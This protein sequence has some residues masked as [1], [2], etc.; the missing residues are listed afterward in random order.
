VQMHEFFLH[1]AMAQLQ[2]VLFGMDEEVME[3]TNS[4]IREVFAGTHKDSKY[5]RDIVLS[6]LRKVSENPAFATATD[7]AV[8]SG[9]K[10][11]FGPLSK[12]VVDA[13]STLNL[14]PLDQ[15]GNMMII[16]FAGHDTTGH[17]M[18]WLCYELSKHPEHLARLQAEVDAMFSSLGGR[19]MAYEDC[20][21]LPF[22][23]R[24]IVETLRLWPVVVNGTFRELEGDETIRGP[25][26]K[27]VTLPAGTF[28]QIPNWM[29]HRDPVLWGPDV[30]VFNP[31]RAFEGSEIWDGVPFHSSNPE[32]ARF[33]PFT[34]APR[35]CLGK[36]FAQLEMRAILSHVLRDF[37]FELS[38]PYKEHG[39]DHLESSFGTTGPRD[40]TPEGVAENARRREEGGFPQ[41][42]MYLHVVPRHFA[43]GSKL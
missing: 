1:E 42:A 18:T 26:G 37:S 32:S 12:S 43:A 33:S 31:D 13:I 27:A 38:A 40:V 35:H 10:P 3:S 6:M 15:F 2:L 8:V 9:E 17:T 41:L 23:T 14:D 21:K 30:D 11:V 39:P 36:N 19:A 28:V 5:G 29:R 7:P 4:N 16:L 24:C 22:M 34:F 25:G 20:Q